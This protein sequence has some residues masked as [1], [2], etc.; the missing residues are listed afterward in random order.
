[1]E[2]I[3]MISLVIRN[4]IGRNDNNSG[5]NSD[6][7]DN[8]VNDKRVLHHEINHNERKKKKCFIGAANYFCLQNVCVFLVVFFNTHVTLLVF[9]FCFLFLFFFA[10]VCLEWIGSIYLSIDC[11]TNWTYW[12]VGF[13]WWTTYDFG[14]YYSFNLFLCLHCI[15]F[16]FWVGAKYAQLDHLFSAF[17]SEFDESS[18]IGCL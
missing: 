15:C 11:W 9:V 12:S 16:V 17:E 3:R 1:M 5:N 4:M 14:M 6:P 18:Y 2:R 7:Y 10:H 13:W 8:W